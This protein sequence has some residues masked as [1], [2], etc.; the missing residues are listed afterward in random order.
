MRIG[1]A[2][3]DLGLEAL[4]RDGKPGMTERELGAIVGSGHHPLDGATVIHFIGR[5][6]H[7][8]FDVVRSAAA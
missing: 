6:Q 4:L 7:Y 5:K 2:L 3:S 1:A 8:Q